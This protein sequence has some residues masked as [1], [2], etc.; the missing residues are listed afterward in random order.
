MALALSLSLA[1]AS[2]VFA[3]GAAAVLSVT[4]KVVAV[5]VSASPN[6]IVI[7]TTTAKRQEMIVGATVARD[8]TITRGNQRLELKD[9]KQGDMVE[10]KYVKGPEGLAA[11]S[12]HV[13]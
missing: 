12:I 11:R 1:A 6:V 9:V 8:V 10:L 13:R 3:A 2:A 4:G 5:N 7:T